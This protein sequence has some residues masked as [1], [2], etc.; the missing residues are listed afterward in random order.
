VVS[1]PYNGLEEWFEVGKEMFIVHNAEEAVETY[2]MLLS[3][4]ELRRRTGE[5]ARRRVLKEHTAQHRAKQLIEILQGAK[6]H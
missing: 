2:K 3:S 1:D 5:A 6:G 4:D